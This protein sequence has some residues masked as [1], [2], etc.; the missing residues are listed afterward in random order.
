[1][2]VDAGMILD[3]NAPDVEIKAGSKITSLD[4]VI[5]T[6]SDDTDPNPTITAINLQGGP[7][8]ENVELVARS[9]GENKY[10]LEYPILFPSMEEGERYR[11]KV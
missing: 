5:I 10:M 8:A 4:E 11:L 3:S 7:F 2:I 9:I 1:E 6:L